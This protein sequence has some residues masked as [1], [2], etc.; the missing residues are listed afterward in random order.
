MNLGNKPLDAAQP[1]N[2]PMPPPNM[3]GMNKVKLTPPPPPT[4]PPVNVGKI[5]PPPIAPPPPMKNLN[6]GPPGIPPPPPGGSVPLPPPPPTKNNVSQ[7]PKPP[8]QPSMNQSLAVVEEKSEKGK[9]KD[10]FAL[11]GKNDTK[12][13]EG[14]SDYFGGAND[15]SK[16][17]SFKCKELLKFTIILTQFSKQKR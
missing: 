10:S 1:P 4:I 7:P 2:V 14:F 3:I 16:D 17:L 9:V 6:K 8:K 12:K 15:K 5:P 11:S 13:D